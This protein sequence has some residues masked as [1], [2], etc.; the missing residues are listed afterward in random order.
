MVA[1]VRPEAECVV[2]FFNGDLES[3]LKSYD[4][5]FVKNTSHPLGTEYE[6]FTRADPSYVCVY[7]SVFVEKGVGIMVISY[8]KQLNHRVINEISDLV[9]LDVP[10]NTPDDRTKELDKLIKESR[11]E[12]V[13]I[14][15]KYFSKLVFS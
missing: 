9:S 1:I 10:E 7:E 14:K 11:G 13:D 8:D 5:R 12:L 6:I 2:G 3:L 4:P 15:L